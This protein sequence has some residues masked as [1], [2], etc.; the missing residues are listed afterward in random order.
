MKAKLCI[1]AI[2]ATTLNLWA[3]QLNLLPGL[4][5]GKITIHVVDED[6]VPIEGAK[7]ILA[8]EEAHPKWGSA[9]ENPVAGITGHGGDFT[10]SGYCPLEV[11]GKAEM[12]GFYLT[13]LPHYQFKTV[14]DGKCQPWNPIVNVVLKKIIQPLPMYAKK[15]RVVVPALDQ[16]IG[17]DLAAGDW[18]KPFGTGTNS[19]FVFTLS[20]TLNNHNDFSAKL[21][22]TFK[23]KGDGVQAIRSSP[24]Q[25]TS[26]LKLPRNAPEDGYISIWSTSLNHGTFGANSAQSE[27]IGYFLRVRSAVQDDKI[28]SAQYGKIDGNISIVGAAAKQPGIAFTYYLN[29]TGTTNLEFDPDKNLLKNLK[30]DDQVQVP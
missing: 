12:L 18:I 2:F 28:K 23:A 11:G 10:G 9:K 21:L 4:P 7:V 20:R 19:D 27:G 13:Y 30:N 17:F 1:F 14:Q 8:F 6:G 5:E 25:G 22:L 3:Q 24:D 15:V 26:Q 29:P 16:P